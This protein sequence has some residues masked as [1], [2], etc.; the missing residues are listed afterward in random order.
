MDTKQTR[1]SLIL[2]YA[3]LLSVYC[4][5]GITAQLINCAHSSVAYEDNHSSANALECFLVLEKSK[6]EKGRVG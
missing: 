4:P 2:R 1:K 6:V 5:S 3:L